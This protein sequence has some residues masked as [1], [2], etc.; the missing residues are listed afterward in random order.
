[1]ANYAL[2]DEN[3]IV[4][5]VIFGKE[6]TELINGVDP[7]TYYGNHLNQ[8]CVRTSYNTIGN[9]HR[10]G[11]TPF[12]KN[13]AKIGDKYDEVGF[14]D[15][16]KPF[17]SWIFNTDTYLY[18]PPTP[19]PIKGDKYRNWNS[20]ISDWEEIDVPD[21]LDYEWN[22]AEQRWKIIPSIDTE[23]NLSN[24]RDPRWDALVAAKDA[25]A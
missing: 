3:N 24:V 2:L 13:F 21:L 14:F 20:E 8:R 12:R 1:M 23:G 4:T 11:G 10:L 15:P 6:E 7:E 16:V 17:E 25:E 22:E 9:T 18:D 5:N 19:K